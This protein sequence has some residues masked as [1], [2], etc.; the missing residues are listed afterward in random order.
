MIKRFLIV[1]LVVFFYQSAFA[2]SLLHK[3]DGQSIYVTEV[4][5]LTDNGTGNLGGNLCGGYIYDS[6]EVKSTA[7]DT[8]TLKINSRLGSEILPAT[9]TTSATTGE[10]IDLERFRVLSCDKQNS[11]YPTYTLTDMSSGSVTIEVTS[12]KR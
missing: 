3:E 2:W 4:I 6:I 1:L 10:Y 9:T 12:V 8:V 7:D 5:T 11:D